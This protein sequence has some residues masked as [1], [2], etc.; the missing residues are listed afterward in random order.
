[1]A[2]NTSGVRLGEVTAALPL[3]TEQVAERLARR[4]LLAMT[5]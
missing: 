5:G 1:M 2:G 4:P 3:A